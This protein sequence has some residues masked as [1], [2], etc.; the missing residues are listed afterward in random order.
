MAFF[1]GLILLSVLYVARGV[2]RWSASAVASLLAG[3]AV[4]VGIALLAPATENANVGY[5]FL[6]GVVAISSMILPGLSGSFVLI[7]MGNYALVLGAI[8]SFSLGVL[9]PLGLGCAFG[10]V[11]FSHLLAW[12]FKRVPDQTLALMT[13]FVLGSLVVIWPWKEALV[14]TVPRS[15]R[16]RAARGGRRLRLVPAGRRLGRHADRAGPDRRRRRRDLADGTAR[17]TGLIPG[18]RAVGSRYRLRAAPAVRGS[19]SPHRRR[20][21]VLPETTWTPSFSRAAPP[22]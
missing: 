16:R 13:G 22:L 19:P 6:C 20:A 4:A 1:F 10:L 2:E 12:V 21:G 3:T 14:D 5:V 15:V 11:A 17:R 18:R 7:I 9:V 8:S